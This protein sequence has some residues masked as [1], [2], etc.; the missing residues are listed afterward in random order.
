MARIVDQAHTG[1]PPGVIHSAAVAM[2]G[3]SKKQ[4]DVKALRR[5]DLD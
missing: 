4:P 3:E 2:G 1:A 5:V